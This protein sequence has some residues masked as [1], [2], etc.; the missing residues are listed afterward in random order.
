MTIKDHPRRLWSEVRDGWT[1]PAPSRAGLTNP[2][3]Q[4][5]RWEWDTDL[6]AQ[7]A[8]AFDDLVEASQRG[9]DFDRYGVIKP[10]LDGLRTYVG[11]ATPTAAQTAAATKALI[12]VLRALLRD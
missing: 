9:I 4:T 2:D 7:D 10:E 6:S 8:V 12:R 3:E 11:I 5:T 1:G